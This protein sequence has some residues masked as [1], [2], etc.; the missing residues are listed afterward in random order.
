ME[1]QSANDS[2]I[3]TIEYNGYQGWQFL[4]ASQNY[5]TTY[6]IYVK[7]Y[8]DKETGKKKAKFRIL[9]YKGKIRLGIYKVFTYQRSGLKYIDI[10]VQGLNRNYITNEQDFDFEFKPN[11][12]LNV[13][14]YLIPMFLLPPDLNKKIEND[15]K[16]GKP[17]PDDIFCK[18]YSYIS[19]NQKVEII[20]AASYALIP[21]NQTYRKLLSKIKKYL[22][23]CPDE[24]NLR[25]TIKKSIEAFS[26]IV[27][28]EFFHI[29]G[30]NFV[31]SKYD[32]DE[33]PEQRAFDP[34]GNLQLVG[35]R[36]KQSTLR[37]NIN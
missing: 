23:K 5:D 12:I 25:N 4:L 7:F 37:V 27:D 8:V 34:S 15:I 33:D 22:K 28:T 32:Y 35:L 9:N 3:A 30:D 1:S 29:D 16:A 13:E 36:C 31:V 19:D 21:N 18:K 24:A 6:G 14:R 26:S 10:L 20:W 11:E 2:L 17:C